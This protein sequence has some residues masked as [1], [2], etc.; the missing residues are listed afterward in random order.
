MCECDELKASF[1]NGLWC[2]SALDM[3]NMPVCE[4][5]INAERYVQFH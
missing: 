2:I 1:C 5:I 4:G 3:G